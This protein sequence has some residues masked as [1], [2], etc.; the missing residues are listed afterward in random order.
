M[1]KDAFERCDKDA[2]CN[3]FQEAFIQTLYAYRI[4]SSRIKDD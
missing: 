1:G 2:G 4:Q 3:L